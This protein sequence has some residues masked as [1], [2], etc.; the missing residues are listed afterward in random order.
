M[1]FGAEIFVVLLC[2]LYLFIYV[3]DMAQTVLQMPGLSNDLKHEELQRIQQG[4]LLWSVSVLVYNS[5][6]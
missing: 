2:H 3:S 4:S 1:K 5:D 6:R